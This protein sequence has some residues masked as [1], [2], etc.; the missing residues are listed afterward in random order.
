M[1]RD[2]VTLNR[3]LAESLNTFDSTRATYKWLQR[4]MEL[5][6]ALQDAESVLAELALKLQDAKGGGIGHTHSAAMNS[7]LKQQEKRIA[8]LKK[9]QELN[10][11]DSIILGL[12][13]YDAN[14]R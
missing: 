8:Q 14:M 1:E 3:L 2:I 4:D 10:D 11:R 7:Q 5:V 13:F 12:N 6:K 9:E